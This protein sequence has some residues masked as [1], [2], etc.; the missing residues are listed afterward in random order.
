MPL[1]NVFTFSV[2][3]A[4]TLVSVAV[5]QNGEIRTCLGIS[6]GRAKND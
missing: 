6:M 1:G 3:A 5:D 2:I 4:D